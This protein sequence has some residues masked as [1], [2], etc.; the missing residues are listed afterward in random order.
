LRPELAQGPAIPETRDASS[1]GEPALSRE[2]LAIAIVLGTP[3]LIGS[4]IGVVAGANLPYRIAQHA[5]RPLPAMW[6]RMGETPRTKGPEWAVSRNTQQTVYPPPTEELTRV[7]AYEFFIH[8]KQE[9]M[10]GLT[11]RLKNCYDVYR[12]IKAVRSRALLMRC[13][14]MDHAITRYDELFREQFGPRGA[15]VPP[16]IYP[17][18]S[19]KSVSER[20]EFTARVLF[21]GDRRAQAVA[22]RSAVTLIYSE[23]IRFHPEASKEVIPDPAVLPPDP[24]PPLKRGSATLTG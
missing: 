1:P 24:P 19:D 5:P 14:V 22:M 2:N 17:F 10:M 3:L 8:Y 4:A 15:P 23:L 13:A 16:S 9:G 6:E 11:S 20:R 7:L 21:G 18:L 12:E